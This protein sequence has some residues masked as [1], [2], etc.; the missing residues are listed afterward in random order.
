MSKR[1]FQKVSTI[2]I[3]LALVISDFREDVLI[4]KLLYFLEN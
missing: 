3:N 1:A 2:W 4:H